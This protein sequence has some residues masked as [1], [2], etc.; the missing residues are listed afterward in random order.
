M[1]ELA[2][3]SGTP[4]E[5]VERVL[6]GATVRE[7]P[8]GDGSMVWRSWGSGP[9]VVLLHGGDGSW[10]HWI[11][12]IPVLARHYR[13]HAADT[14]G[15]GDSAMPPEPYTPATIAA[16]IAHGIDE[17]IPP[18]QLFDLV[19]F[20]FGGIL[21]GH[22]AALH[23]ERIAS[24]TLVGPGALGLQH[25][26][27]ALERMRPEMTEEER[28]GTQRHNLGQ[29]LI[30]D[31]ANIDDLAIH[32]QTENVRRGRTRSRQFAVT[33]VLAQVLKQTTC[34][35]NGVWGEL[36]QVAAGRIAEREALLKSIRPDVDFRVIPG[37][38]HWVAYE[39]AE[40][41]NAM[42]LDL[43]ARSPARKA[44]S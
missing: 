25:G 22:L 2:G 14:P 27:V 31:P 9:P 1:D 26:V 28:A 36:D 16:I 30:A 23:G 10:R 6:A 32:I 19:G 44:P 40:A 7:T 41:F 21:G 37:A 29:L 17:V 18:P 11:R 3:L 34:K 4:I 39:A 15:L 24:A 12:N 8:C 42:L 5:I 35:L 43:L 20:S 38:G 13:V 33:D